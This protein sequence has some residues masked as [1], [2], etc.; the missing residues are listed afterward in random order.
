MSSPDAVQ[1]SRRC[2]ACTRGERTNRFSASPGRRRHSRS[3]SASR[4][5]HFTWQEWANALAKEIE[6]AEA[7]GELDDGMRY[8]QRWLSA[9]ERLV[10]EPGLTEQAPLDARKE[11]WAEAYRRTPHGKLVE[12]SVT[13]KTP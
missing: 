6:Q 13:A 8:Y 9:L 7:R 10:R 3:P 4:Q 12:L 5:G 2:C 1:R 11:D